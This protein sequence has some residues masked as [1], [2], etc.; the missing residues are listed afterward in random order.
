[1]TCH[2]NGYRNVA[3]LNS[4]LDSIA[5]YGSVDSINSNNGSARLCLMVGRFGREL[6]ATWLFKNVEHRFNEKLEAVRADFR[7][8]EKVLE[9]NLQLRK[10]RSEIFVVEP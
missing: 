1:M 10:T 4:G 9:A 3:P 8:K 7:E 6:I 5:I 2:S